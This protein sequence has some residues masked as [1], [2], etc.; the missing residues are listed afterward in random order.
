MVHRWHRDDSMVNG[1]PG[2]AGMVIEV[3]RDAEMVADVPGDD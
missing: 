1:V 3:L 2:D